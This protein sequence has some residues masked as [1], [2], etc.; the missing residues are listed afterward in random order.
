M[1]NTLFIKQ[2]PTFPVHVCAALTANDRG[3]GMRVFNTAEMSTRLRNI[4]TVAAQLDLRRRQKAALLIFCEGMIVHRI[5]A[6]RVPRAALE[7]Q[8]PR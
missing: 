3:Y 2:P 5:P 4:L 1:A 8:K 6:R 7:V